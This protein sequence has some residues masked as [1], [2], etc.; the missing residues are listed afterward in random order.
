MKSDLLQY[1]VVASQE[2]GYPTL[3]IRDAVFGIALATKLENPA[4]LFSVL[5]LDSGQQYIRYFF[6]A[7]GKL[8]TIL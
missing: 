2:R 8:L 4:I 5:I 7:S 6:H 1:A 3:V